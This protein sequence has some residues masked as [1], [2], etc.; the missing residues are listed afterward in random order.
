MTDAR[1]FSAAVLKIDAPAVS[2]RI[3]AQ[4]RGVVLHRLRRRGVVVGL[5]G[6]VD[7]SVVAAL[8]VRAL[9]ANRVIGLLMPEA[10][11]SSD[12]L[13][14]GRAVA[15]GLR[16]R[17]VVEDIS[18]TLRAVGCYRRRDDAIRLA[19]PEYGE[20]Y[21]CKVVLPDVI[22]RDAYSVSFLTIL[23]PSGEARRVRLSA[24]AYLGIVAATNFKQRVRKMLEYYYADRF[25][26]AVAGTPNLLEH[27]QGFFVKNGD[28]SAD[29]K[30]IAHLYKSQVYQLAAH[31]DLP[32]EIQRRAPTTDTYPLEQSQEEFYFG[33][34][35]L[36]MD[37]C[38]FAKDQGFAPEDAAPA[39]GLTAEQTRRA[40][41]L[42]D[43]KREAARYLHAEPMLFD[44]RAA[45]ANV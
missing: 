45:E 7:S 22:D 42:I 13:R 25:R 14:L 37:L 30:P 12:S 26:M 6:G 34:S 40:Y 4:I 18:E 5:S 19:V 17:Y 16:I 36:K 41:A 8:A 39:I 9:G 44:S 20:G 23:A 11:S 10:D 21:K 29:L 38:V 27:D 24:E 1:Q 43:S 33:L 32:A 2:A 31:L 35:L 3:E 15:D 28:G